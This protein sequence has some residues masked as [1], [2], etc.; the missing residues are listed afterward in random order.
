M[1]AHAQPQFRVLLR[2]P[3]NLQRAF[4]RRFRTLVKDQRHAIAG[5]DFD[6]PA[7]RFSGLE[8]IRATDD[9]V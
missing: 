9:L 3:A 2:R 1:N 7:C 5:R 4:N 8:F 6:Q